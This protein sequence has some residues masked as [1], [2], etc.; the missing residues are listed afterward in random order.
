[1]T[2]S[3]VGRKDQ[4]P[5]PSAPILVLT[6]LAREAACLHGEGV[7]PLCSGADVRVLRT[8]L[9]LLESSEF[10]AVVSFGLAGGLDYGL[11][12]GD[13]VIGTQ[14]IGGSEIFETH[15]ALRRVLAEGFAGAGVPVRE[16]AV[17]G[18]DAAI[19][20]VPAKT[21]LRASGG[22]IAVDMEFASRRRLRAA[23]RAALRHRSG[24]QRS[25][26]TRPAP[27]GDKSGQARRKRRRER[28]VAGAVARTG[29]DRRSDPRGSRRPRGF[30]DFRPLWRSGRPAAST[31]ALGSVTAS[32][33][34]RRTHIRPGAGFR[35]ICRA[36]SDL[37]CSRRRARPS[38]RAMGA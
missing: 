3:L 30:R 32:L 34:W 9:E 25:G 12:P 33:H 6:G 31:R 10:S 21:V 1:M 22:A 35:A 38:A 23:A 20:T 11:A 15:P 8:A 4:G 17:R 37:R 14:A 2:R 18:V 19:L 7:V 5:R 24:R 13:A 36:P 28:R 16:G 29:T 26:F 27:A